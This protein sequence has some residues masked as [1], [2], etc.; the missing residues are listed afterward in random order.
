[1]YE[2]KGGG[3]RV[4]DKTVDPTGLLYYEFLL[5]VTLREKK[6]WEMRS[7]EEMSRKRSESVEDNSSKQ[8]RKT[9]S[10]IKSHRKWKNI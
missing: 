1:M 10:P 6:Y 5:D 7:E 4:A 2:Y 9:E 8:S 3:R